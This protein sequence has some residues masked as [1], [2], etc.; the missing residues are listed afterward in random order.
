M[1]RPYSSGDA[2]GVGTWSPLEGGA[3]G[4]ARGGSEGAGF[5]SFSDISTTPSTLG[6]PPDLGFDALNVEGMASGA[7]IWLIA[8]LEIVALAVFGL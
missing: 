7:E 1:G 4:G 6:W 8:V 5:F 3:S 2:L